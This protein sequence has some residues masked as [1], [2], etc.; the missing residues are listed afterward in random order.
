MVQFCT[1]TC[2]TPFLVARACLVAAQVADGRLLPGWHECFVN[3]LRSYLATRL[4]SHT[5]NNQSMDLLTHTQHTTARN[6]CCSAQ[7]HASTPRMI[8]I[9]GACLVAAQVAGRRL[10][11]G[12]SM[13]P[14]LH[15]CA[16][17]SQA[18]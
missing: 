11:P 8:C 4:A 13:R 1:K 3:R 7:G 10:L 18:R 12:S 5:I 15:P 6:R 9:V 17:T 14:L 2:I 16:A